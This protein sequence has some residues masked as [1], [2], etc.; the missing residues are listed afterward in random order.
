MIIDKGENDLLELNVD[1]K[2]VKFVRA[3]LNEIRRC[4]ES[5]QEAQLPLVDDTLSMFLRR[6]AD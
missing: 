1:P 4:R 3:Q 6:Q 2:M 5:Q